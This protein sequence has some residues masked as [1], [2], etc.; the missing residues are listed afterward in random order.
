MRLYKREQFH[1]GQAN[2]EADMMLNADHHAFADAY[3]DLA[4]LI[5]KG[6]TP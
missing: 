2:R 4:A 5:E 3:A 1:I 6:P